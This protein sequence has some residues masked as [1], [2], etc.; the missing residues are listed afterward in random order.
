MAVRLSLLFSVVA[1]ITFAGVGAYLFQ[2]F[3]QKIEL[4]D[5]SDLVYKAM[6]VKQL[7][8]D[9][10]SLSELARTPAVFSVALYGREGFVLRV[11]GPEQQPLMQIAPPG[12]PYP[13]VPAQH[14][15]TPDRTPV[16]T[17]V[18]SWYAGEE[19][20]R[21]LTATGV[22]GDV[23]STQVQIVI[24]RQ[25]STHSAFLQNYLINLAYAVGL[26]ATLVAGLGFLIVRRGMRP[27]R[28]V[29]E[30]ANTISTHR[31]NTRLLVKSG[32]AEILD[33]GAAFDAMLDRLEEGV[34]RLSRFAADL[35]H[36]LR[37]PINTLM[38]E[39]QVVLSRPRTNDEYQ[40]LIVSNID[41]YERLSRMI[42][43]TLFLARADNAQLALTRE[44]LDASQELQRI[45]NYFSGLADDAGINLS[46]ESAEANESKSIEQLPVSPG[47]SLH[48]DPILLRRALSN[49]VSNAIAHTPRGG[50][51]VL[52]VHSSPMRLG[53]DVTNTGEGICTEHMPFIFD[54]YYRA[55]SART[56]GS[57]AGVGL[58]IVR[59]IMHLHGGE[60]IAHSTPGVQTTFS[61]R[62]NT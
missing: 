26:G 21:M 11:L 25:R 32:P 53:I 16:V 28:R 59:A 46:V 31:L 7:L 18:R 23:S 9:I 35:A 60:I 50:S 43:N 41:E 42:E 34:Q 24:S 54:R 33:L 1:A 49:L 6:L 5:D 4:R 47:P 62:F 27:L 44:R 2:V 37:T 61:L 14:V 58:A 55:D 48:A 40:A 8:A 52:S 20:G 30:Q 3:V 57:S 12:Q 10:P 22:L 51:V 39:T 45:R 15:L 29:I 56:K 17:D 38:M 19:E 13:D 36:D